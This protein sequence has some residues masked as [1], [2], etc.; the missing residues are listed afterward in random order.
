MVKDIALLNGAIMARYLSAQRRSD[1]TAIG[2]S[3]MF[4]VW[5]ATMQICR[6][7]TKLS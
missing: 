4:N 6:T 1:A 5:F 7:Q 3:S 2:V